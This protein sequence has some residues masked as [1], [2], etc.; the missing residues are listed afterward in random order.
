V[1]VEL[2]ICVGDLETKNNVNGSDS[3]KIGMVDRYFRGPLKYDDIEL[4]HGRRDIT[5]YCDR[6]VSV[7]PKMVNG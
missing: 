6:A 5:I 2:F 1:R 4:V 7:A 3:M